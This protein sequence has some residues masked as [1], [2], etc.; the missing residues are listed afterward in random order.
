MMTFMNDQDGIIATDQVSND[1]RI[2]SKLNF[3][4]AFCELIN[5]K[6]VGDIIFEFLATL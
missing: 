3:F 4:S 2:A 1:A 5:V 6:L